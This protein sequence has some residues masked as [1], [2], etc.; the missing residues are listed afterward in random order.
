LICPVSRN[1]VYISD[2][3]S[4]QLVIKRLNTETSEIVEVVTGKDLKS[5]IMLS[6]KVST[7][8]ANEELVVAGGF[9]GQYVC[10]RVDGVGESLKDEGLSEG[11][12]TR[13]PTGITNHVSILGKSSKTPGRV[14]FASN[15]FYVREFDVQTS[16]FLNCDK[17]QWAVNCSAYNPRNSNMRLLVGDSIMGLV[18]DAAANKTI[19]TLSGHSDYGFACSW[20]SD[21]YTLATG[22]QDGTCRVFDIRN[23]SKAVQ[24]ISSQLFGAIRS[25]TF[26][27]SGR[28]LAFSE[29]IDYVTILDANANYEKGQV[30]ELYGDIGGIGFTEG[31]YGGCQYLTIG[32]CDENFGGIFQYERKDYLPHVYNSSESFII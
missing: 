1:E 4:E 2:Y 11:Y 6:T 16:K 17:Y 25:L 9:H 19:A 31:A 30:I 22:N 3:C 8:A 28:F 10:K 12:V 7:L 15:D 13:D 29:P 24:V 5:N 26:D 20:S 14:I 23:T 32:N 27:S 21:G 18:V